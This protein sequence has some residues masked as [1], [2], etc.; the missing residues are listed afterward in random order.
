MWGLHAVTV[1]VGA[2]LVYAGSAKV[3]SPRR[4]TETLEGLRLAALATPAIV[5]ALGLA[6][7]GL[8]WLLSA[9]DWW[10]VS[11]L[12][13]VLGTSFALVGVYALREHLHV[14]CNCIGN[15]DKPLGYRQVALLPVWV[16]IA[17]VAQMPGRELRSAEARLV[18]TA[19]AT[20]IATL[21]ASTQFLLKVAPVSRERRRPMKGEVTPVGG[22]PG[23]DAF[24]LEWR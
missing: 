12:V 22:R 11:V 2:L 23:G 5:R 13:I 15:S 16:L 21:F 10:L 17:W 7:I 9:A 4:L 19:V 1:T 6:E 8:G 18:A 14:A 20:L 24:G 3:A